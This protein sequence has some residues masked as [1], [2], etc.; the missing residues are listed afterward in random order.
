MPS[1]GEY[2]AVWSVPSSVSENDGLAGR[3]KL[4]PAVPLTVAVVVSVPATAAVAP[5]RATIAI[6]KEM[7]MRCLM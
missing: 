3:F 5:V 7:M 6:A 4:M 1:S 2:A